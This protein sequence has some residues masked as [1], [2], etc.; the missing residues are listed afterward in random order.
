MSLNA[1]LLRSS[2]NEAAEREAMVTSRFYPLLFKR[3]PQVEPLF[4]KN[5][6]ERQQQMLQ[7]SLL[8][9]LENLEDG[10]WLSE[11]LG[12]LGA[13]HVDYEV[14]E[15][16]YGWVGECLIDTLAEILEDQWTPE[17]QQAWSDA[18]NAVSGL[19]IAG[20]RKRLA[21]ASA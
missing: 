10:E 9:V 20:A 12:N 13:G 15:E 17:H 18:L 16:M 7:E 19:M 1:D 8:A 6:P 5:D 11:T 4:S 14:T 3:Y 2:L 21:A